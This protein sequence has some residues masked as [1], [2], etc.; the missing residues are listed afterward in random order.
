MTNDKIKRAGQMHLDG[1]SLNAIASKL[2]E[3][4]A[5]V[6]EVL[7]LDGGASEVK[8]PEARRPAPKPSR[9]G[10]EITCITVPKLPDT[11]DVGWLGG[12]YDP[13]PRDP[14]G[15]RYRDGSPARLPL[16]AL[17]YRPARRHSP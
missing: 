6:R 16:Y 12:V 5:W 1:Q 14:Q 15:G 11:R 13:R 2:G 7:G 17:P 3:S 10:G 4:V 8:K 9:A